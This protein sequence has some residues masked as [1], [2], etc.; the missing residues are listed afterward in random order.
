MKHR[1]KRHAVVQP[2]DTSYRVIPLTKGQNAIVDAEDFEHINQWNWCAQWCEE[3]QSFY[4]Q[5]GGG[6]RIHQV[7][8]GCKWGDHKNHDTLDNRREN[9]RKCTR[10]QNCRNARIRRDNTSGFKGVGWHERI[11]K[12]EARI[13]V[14]K[15]QKYL[16]VFASKEDAARAYDIAAEVYHREFALKNFPS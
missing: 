8:L 11:K 6:V 9:L 5:R 2:L 15:K 1:M 4:A 16:G 13:V 14:N 7:I 3:T 10:S 12:W